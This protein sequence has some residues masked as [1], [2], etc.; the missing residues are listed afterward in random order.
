MMVKLPASLFNHFAHAALHV[1]QNF[2]A[3]DID[4]RFSLHVQQLKQVQEDYQKYTLKGNL[5]SW[6]KYLEQNGLI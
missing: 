1:I 2:A 3:Q 4:L 5:Q 6:T